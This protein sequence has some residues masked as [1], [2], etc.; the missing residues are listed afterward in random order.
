MQQFIERHRSAIVGTLSGFDR[1]RFRGTLRWLAHWQGMKCF[2]QYAKVLWKDFTK[3]AQDVTAEVRRSSGELAETLGRPV[4]YLVGSTASKEQ[5]ARQIAQQ[6]G[7]TEGLICVLTCVEPCMTYR[8]GPNRERRLLELRHINAKCLHHY[9]YSID[10]QLGFMH[11]RLQTWFPFTVHVCL[12]GREWLARQ[13]DASR[14]GYVRRDNCFVALDQPMAAQELMNA[15]LQTH[16]S[17]LLDA[18]VRRFHPQHARLFKHPAL[19]YYWSA[20]ETEWATDVMF[21]SKSA[22]DAVYG[23]LL[24]HG[25]QAMGCVDVLRFLGQRVP[26][27]GQVHG[28]FTGELSTDL[29]ARP[30]GVRLKHR[31]RGNSVKMYNKQGSVLRVETTLNNVRQL[32]SYRAKEGEPDGPKQWRPMKKGVSDLHR[33]AELSHAANERYLASMAQVDQ[34]TTLGD[35]TTGLC[36]RVHWRGRPARALNPFSIDDQRLLAAVNDGQFAIQGFRNRDLRQPLYGDKPR[37]PA[38]ASRQSAKITRQLRLLRA[39]RLIRKLPKTHRY[40]L[41]A[42]GRRAIAALIIAQQTDTAKL[43]SYAA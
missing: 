21:R 29:R 20:E 1:V 11:L 4:I 30:E 15:Q 31:L 10:P 34:P 6:D 41:T 26:A 23:R 22:L 24:G 42:R 36:R 13:M 9:F 39:H 19:R 12:N 14:L 3:Y 7:V 32:K 5:V 33:R 27:H 25:M 37:D 28:K 18:L 40:L 35:L 2:L 8:V 16:W 17:G 38:A 43:A